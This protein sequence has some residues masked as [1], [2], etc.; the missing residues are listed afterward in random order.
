MPA[1]P[2]ALVAAVDAPQPGIVTVEPVRSADLRQ[3]GAF[4][5]RANAD[6]VRQSIGGR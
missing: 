2:P 4:S 6:R 3:A 1:P 5:Q